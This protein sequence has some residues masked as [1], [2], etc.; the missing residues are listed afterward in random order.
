MEYHF[1]WNGMSFYMAE[2]TD[3]S[4]MNDSHVRKKQNSTL[5]FH[6]GSMYGIPGLPPPLK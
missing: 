4:K 5:E 3:V 2:R 6:I 1:T